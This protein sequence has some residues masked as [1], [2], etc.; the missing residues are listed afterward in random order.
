[1][2]TIPHAQSWLLNITL[3][4]PL[5]Y[6]AVMEVLSWHG[7]GSPWLHPRDMRAETDLPGITYPGDCYT[8]AQGSERY[9]R[10]RV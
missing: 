6:L 10:H 7:C 8:V 3:R 1:M 4:G 9:R 5:E 2:V